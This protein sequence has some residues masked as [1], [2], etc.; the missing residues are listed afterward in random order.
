LRTLHDWWQ[1]RQ[2]TKEAEKAGAQVEQEAKVRPSERFADLKKAAEGMGD[3]KDKE[4]LL[5]L[6]EVADR[7]HDIIREF[8]NCKDGMRSFSIKMGQELADLRRWRQR[9]LPM[10]ELPP[11]EDKVVPLRRKDA[12]VQGQSAHSDQL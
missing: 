2:E 12:D 1:Q 5:A 4:D 9:F 6:F 10:I 11:E 8:R 3:C 7:Q